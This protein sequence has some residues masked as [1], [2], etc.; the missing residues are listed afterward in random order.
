MTEDAVEKSLPEVT[1]V[2]EVD[3]SIAAFRAEARRAAAA[4]AK[5]L[6]VEVP[7]ENDLVVALATVVGGFGGSGSGSGGRDP[8]G[9]SV[10]A[11]SAASGE[12][13]AALETFRR[14]ISSPA[15]EQIGE[16]SSARASSGGRVPVTVALVD[17]FPMPPSTHESSRGSRGFSNDPNDSEGSRKDSEGS[18]KDDGAKDK[19]AFVRRAVVSSLRAMRDAVARDGALARVMRV[20][21]TTSVARDGEPGAAAIAVRVETPLGDA[22]RRTSEADS[23]TLETLETLETPRPSRL[24]RGDE[25]RREEKAALPPSSPEPFRDAF[26]RRSSGKQKAV[27]PVDPPPTID[28]PSVAAPDALA[29]VPTTT[30][31]HDFPCTSCC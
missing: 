11:F 29:P 19:D 25:D 21:Q 13:V 26:G 7:D 15:Y 2:T 27:S 10:F 16:G 5:A 14:A 23:E 9:Q 6:D 17:R 30:A 28:G 18:R 1:E 22:K 8:C 24:I 20:T 3:V 12:A 4:A 31:S